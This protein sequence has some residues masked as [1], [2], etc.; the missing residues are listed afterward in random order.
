MTF[1]D[2]WN[3]VSRWAD[4]QEKT[5]CSL[6]RALTSAEI[7]IAKKVGVRVP[8]K[9]RVLIL[10]RIPFPEDPKIQEIGAKVGLTAER[11]GALTLHYGIFMRADQAHLTGIWPHEFRHV[12]QYE[13]FGSIKNFMFFYLKEL[14]HF[15]YGG[16]PLE[17]DAV[18]AER[19]ISTN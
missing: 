7:E 9:I 15:N 18:I 3:S 14:L 16:G 6:G 2:L 8:E 13:C 12:A 1:D 5:I 10:P 19:M 11:S 17:V 4:E